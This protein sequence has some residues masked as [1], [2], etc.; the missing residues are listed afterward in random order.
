[1]II[2]NQDTNVL[3]QRML[4]AGFMLLLVFA[5]GTFGL[6]ALGRAYLP[7]EKQWPLGDCAYMTAISVTTVG[8]GEVIEVSKVPFGRLVIVVIIFGGLGVAVYFASTLTTFF[9]E[10]E[11]QQY[12]KRRKMEQQISKVKDHIIVCGIGTSGFHIVEELIATKWRIVCID[13]SSERIER[14]HDLPRANTVPCILGDATDDDV[15][16]KAG[17]ERARGLITALSSDKDNLFVVISARELARKL[18]PTL[19]IVAKAV[20]IHTSEKLRRAGADTVVTPAYIGGIRMV[21]EMIRPNVTEFLDLML[22]DKDKNLRVEEVNLPPDSVLIG[23]PLSEARIRE[24]ANLLVVAVRTA[25]GGP[26]LYNPGPQQ[27]LTNGMSLV[28]LG[29]AD[30]VGRLR[31]HAGHAF[32]PGGESAAV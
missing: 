10:G 26:F 24:M 16:L 2:M 13:A 21:S 25:P 28:V 20:D 19:K 22:R 4:I 23:K 15:L 32:K 27:V 14:I 9:V 1:M 5:G 12:R 17:V 30:A 7:P 18:N 31:E 29:D 11:F 8:Y 3:R 6:W